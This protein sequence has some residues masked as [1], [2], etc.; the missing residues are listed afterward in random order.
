[1][2]I[3]FSQDTISYKKIDNIKLYLEI[4]RPKEFDKT[5]SYPA[6]IFFFGGGW[7][8][9]TRKHF[10][11]H[12]KYFSQRGVMCFLADYR[13]QNSHGTTP[14][15]SLKDAKSAI[16]FIRKNVDSL[17]IHSNK[18]IAS[19]GSA[20]G[21]LA[22]ASAMVSGFEEGTDDLS[23][24]SVP[25]ALVLFNPVIDN[26]P[27]GYGYERIGEQYKNFSPLH[28]VKKGN[29]P[30]I[31]FSGTDDHLIPVQTLAY[32]KTI[33]EKVGTRCDL[34]LFDNQG[35]GFFNYRH[36]DTYKSTVE[37][38]DSFLQSIGFL[39]ETPIIKIK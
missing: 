22:A 32:F 4:Y 6:I 18:I 2:K 15:E 26:G 13:I 5:M 9:G 1:M 20:G 36:F 38:T 16:R 27:G 35:H 33:L 34:H 39:K 24:S 7:I 30:T 10:V 37:T 19:G 21:Q 25:D 23:I 28:N 11:P 29:P 12:A 31:I 14:F 3:G 17:H 8:E